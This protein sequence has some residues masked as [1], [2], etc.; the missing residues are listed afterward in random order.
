MGKKKSSF[1]VSRNIPPA[2]LRS[3]VVTTTTEKKIIKKND[4]RW[5]SFIEFLSA[6]IHL[7]SSI[8]FIKL[9]NELHAMSLSSITIGKRKRPREEIQDQTSEQL[10]RDDSNTQVF[11]DSENSTI[12]G[13]LN[14]VIACLSGFAQNEKEDLHR[15]ILSLGGR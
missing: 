1:L 8:L 3:R 9:W 2:S 13:P 11:N 7:K 12:G 14:G 4:E 6:R 10:K 15:L 5:R